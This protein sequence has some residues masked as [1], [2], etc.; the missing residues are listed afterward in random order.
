MI[1]VTVA[2]Y[3]SQTTAKPKAPELEFHLK[4]SK[5]CIHYNLNHFNGKLMIRWLAEWLSLLLVRTIPDPC[6]LSLALAQ[7]AVALRGDI[8]RLEM[9]NGKHWVTAQSTPAHLLQTPE[10]KHRN[11]S[12]EEQF[13]K[14][15][16]LLIP[17]LQN[18]QDNGSPQL[19][20]LVKL[21]CIK[22]Q[23]NNFHTFILSSLRPRTISDI[24]IVLHVVIFSNRTN[25]ISCQW[26]D[27]LILS[28][29]V[30]RFMSRV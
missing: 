24:F 15:V 21:C 19:S 7:F 14:Y 1:L 22:Y 11:K 20:I 13:R 6:I 2:I 4:L 9:N 23:Q 17:F 8:F 27:L 5:I 30:F 18:L 29:K 16:F 28:R 12:R 3:Q 25:Y 26:L 10:K